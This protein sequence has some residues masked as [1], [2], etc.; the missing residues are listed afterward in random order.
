[1]SILRKET[2]LLR[3]FCFTKIPLLFYVK[4][5]VVKVTE[6]ETVVMIPFLRRNRN[7]LNSMYFGTLCIGADIAGGYIVTRLMKREKK[8]KPSLVFKDFQARFLRRPEGDTHFTCKDGLAIQ[9]AIDK[10]KDTME[11]V[12][13]PVHVVATVPKI[14]GDEPVAEFDL[15]LS[16]RFKA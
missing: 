12:E 15:T 5:S 2:F 10:A 13:V 7:H 3:T 14:S 16:V 11:R 9:A 4:P 6:A 8:R 1:M